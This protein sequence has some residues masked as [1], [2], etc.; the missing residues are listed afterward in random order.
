MLTNQLP[1][2]SPSSEGWRLIIDESLGKTR[3]IVQH[4]SWLRPVTV[5]AA[6]LRNRKQFGAAIVEQIC[7]WPEEEHLDALLGHRDGRVWESGV[8]GDLLDRARE[9]KS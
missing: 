6:T 4:E 7:V 1:P 9:A 3:F 8:I 5:T 2:A